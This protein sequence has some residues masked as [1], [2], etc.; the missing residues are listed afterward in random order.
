MGLLLF[1]SLFLLYFYRDPERKIEPGIVSPADGLVQRAEIKRGIVHLSIFMNVHN[2]HVNR[3]PMS[4]TISKRN[5]IP[6]LFFNASLDK[7]S[8]ENEKKH[9]K[10]I[11][12]F[13]LK[14]GEPVKIVDLAEQ[15]IKLSG[16]ST[17]DTKNPKLN[18]KKIVDVVAG[19]ATSFPVKVPIARS[20]PNRMAA[21]VL[22]ETELSSGISICCAERLPPAKIC[23][24]LL[25][26]K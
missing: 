4:G 11:K 19:T 9:A 8:N 22:P 2:V 18:H 25:S 1:I 6:G 20:I 5:Y 16:L 26:S 17:K 7:E 24:L 3:S 13:L 15:M 21:L 14:M 23:N 10:K 12:K